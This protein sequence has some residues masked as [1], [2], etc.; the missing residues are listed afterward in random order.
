MNSTALDKRYP[1][2]L[3]SAVI[4]FFFDPQQRSSMPFI[5]Y[6]TSISRHECTKVFTKSQSFYARVQK[7]IYSVVQ[8]LE[9]YKLH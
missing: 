5:L 4:F 1:F 7:L 9:I 6:H 8:V 3:H 2:F